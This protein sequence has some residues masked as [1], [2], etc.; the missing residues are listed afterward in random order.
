MDAPPSRL[1]PNGRPCRALVPTRRRPS[2]ASFSERSVP[3]IDGQCHPR[4][5]PV[6]RRCHAFPLRTKRGPN[7]T[8]NAS[9][10]TLLDP[11][12]PGDYNQA[13]MELGATVC[14]KT[15]PGLP[16]L[17]CPPPLP[18]RAKRHGS[19]VSRG[20]RGRAQE[21]VE[22]VRLWIEADG[23][24]LCS[25]EGQPMAGGSNR[26]TNCPCG[27]TL[28]QA[29]VGDRLYQAA[30]H[31]PLSIQKP[32][33]IHRGPPHRRNYRKPPPSAGCPATN[34]NPSRSPASS[35]LGAGFAQRNRRHGCHPR[36]LPFMSH[37]KQIRAVTPPPPPNPP[38]R[39]RR[40]PHRPGALRR[41]RLCRGGQGVR[42]PPATRNCSKSV[43]TKAFDKLRPITRPS[44]EKVFLGNR[45]ASCLR[46]GRFG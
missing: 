10:A 5:G 35:P 46:S 1:P 8:L 25:H 26:S 31:N 6:D 7:A 21:K 19:R 42:R 41:C 32:E 2:P 22:Q 43:S 18:R 45:R 38:L 17:S 24:L 11:D 39:H 16:P 29:V 33:H 13:M 12:T 4:A 3:V 34:W 14:V 30:H 36:S 23:G 9:P 37:P 20:P 15:P 28:P 44:A 40:H 27:E